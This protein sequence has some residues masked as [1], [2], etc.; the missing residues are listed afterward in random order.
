MR[1]AVVLVGAGPRG[2]GLVERLAANAPELYGAASLDLHL[3]DPPPP[4]GG[5]VWRRDQ[6]PLLW[7]NSMA[8]DV[9]MFTDT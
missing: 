2:T 5:R 1:P 9:T 7:M 3:V 8:E 6:S 4:G